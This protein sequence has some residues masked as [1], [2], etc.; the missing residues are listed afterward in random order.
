MQ[1]HTKKVMLIMLITVC[2]IFGGIF[3]FQAF[4]AHKMQ[5]AMMAMAMPPITVTAMQVKYQDWQPQAKAAGSV[6]AVRGVDVTTEIAGLVRSIVFKPGADVQ[7]G[8]LLVQLNIDS[9]VAQLHSLQAAAELAQTVYNRDKAQFAIKAISKATL[10]ADAAALKSAEAQV[11][12]QMANIAKKTIRAPFAGRLGISYVNPGQ[13]VNP[14]DKIVTLQTLDPIYVD[15]SLPQQALAQLAPGQKVVISSD[16]YPEQQF[17][18]KITTVDPKVDVATRNVQIEATLE[19]AKHLLLPGMFVQVNARTGIAERYLT[20]PQTAVNFNPYG[21]IVF[22][23]HESGKDAYGKSKLTVAQSFVTIGKT[24][25]DQVAILEGLK[26]GDQVVTSGGLKLKNG[27]VVVI[28]NKVLPADNPAP[29]LP[30][31]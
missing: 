4:K 15:F 29:Q 7:E 30:E 22:I 27:S 28:D 8:E 24:R 19:N 23:I 11:T 1:H 14:G 25:G 6:R 17:N 26:E 21:E 13:Y 20:L 9:D 3:G 10:D 5:Q 31:E 12:E 2:V 18:G 16:T